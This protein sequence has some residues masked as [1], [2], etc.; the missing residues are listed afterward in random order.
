MKHLLV[1][2]DFSDVTA[3]VVD[4]AAQLAKSLGAQITLLHVAPGEPEFV[5]YEPG[6]QSVRDNVAR[7]IHEEHRRLQELDKQ[8]EKRGIA[9]KSL[10]VQGY[11][12]EKILKESERLKADLI[13]MGSHGHGALRSLLVGSVTDG[14]LRKSKS[15]VL[16]VPVVE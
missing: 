8:L 11:P 12:I 10:L 5:G 3:G 13:V 15:P 1:P 14:V 6:P 9:T 7:E 16:I 2:V 4:V